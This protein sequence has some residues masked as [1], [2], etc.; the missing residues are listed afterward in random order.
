MKLL[1]SLMAVLFASGVPVLASAQTKAPT[2]TLDVVL[3]SGETRQVSTTAGEQVTIELPDEIEFGFLPRLRGSD[4]SHV[5]VAIVKIG[6]TDE[7]LGTVEAKVGE[8]AVESKT[9][10][11]FKIAVSKVTPPEEG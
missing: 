9:T 7:P 2:V 1:T 10:P 4:A 11:V 3:T 6:S 5:D 8:A